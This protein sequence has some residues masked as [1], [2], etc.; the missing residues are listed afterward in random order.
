MKIVHL[1]ARGTF[2]S[3]T[4]GEVRRGNRPVLT[5]PIEG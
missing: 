4:E 3:G 2:I 5:V 1:F